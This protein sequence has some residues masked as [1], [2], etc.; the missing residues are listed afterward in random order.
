MGNNHYDLLILGGGAAGL[1]CALHSPAAWRTALLEAG[2]GCGKKLS[3]CGG[4]RAN[5]SN[6][7]I[8]PNNYV[9]GA[10]ASFLK[11]ALKSFKTGQMLELLRDLGLEW[12]E[13]ARGGLFL[14]TAA[15]NFAVLLR[16]KCLERG[17][18]IR[19]NEKILEIMPAKNGFAVKSANN[20]FQA[21]KIV[22]AL[23]SPA[24]PQLGGSASGLEMARKLGHEVFPPRPALV[25]MLYRKGEYGNLRE[26]AGLSIPAIVNIA[27]ASLA[28]D[29][30]LFT[31][32]GLSGPAILRASLLWREN[33]ALAINFLPEHDFENLLDSFPASTPRAILR[34]YLPPRLVDA[35]LPAELARRKNAEISRRNRRELASR[36]HKFAPQ[37]LEAAGMDK[38]EIC[39]G[40]VS[41]LEINPKNMES[42]LWPGL[43]MAGEMLDVAGDLGGYNLH[44]AFASAR[45]AARCLA[46]K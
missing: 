45:L 1:F 4:G 16:R 28:Q 13:R 23:G 24:H 9:C 25:P 43:H 10:G 26:L 17:C 3:A 36:I 20:F 18:E 41:A 2:G 30:L 31:H 44:W 35:L 32:S 29:D 11:P 7:R 8:S 19:E 33:A 42:R 21:K 15:K 37:N 34:D 27:G 38:A 14:K 40:G 46:Q 6:R 12:K 5:F 22:L 39:A